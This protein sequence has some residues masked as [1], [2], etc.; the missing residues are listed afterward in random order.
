MLTF[1]Q[2]KRWLKIPILTILDSHETRTQN[3]IPNTMHRSIARKQPKQKKKK[4]KTT[5]IP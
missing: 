5:G 1:S 4:K 2:S 3:T